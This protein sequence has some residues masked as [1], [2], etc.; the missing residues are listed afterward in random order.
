M[1]EPLFHVI[2]EGHPAAGFE[3][4]V[5]ATQL[6]QQL[7]LTAAQAGRLLGGSPVIAKRSVAHAVA[8]KYCAHLGALGLRVRIEPAAPPANHSTAPPSTPESD[9][10][11]QPQS[12]QPTHANWLELTDFFNGITTPLPQCRNARYVSRVLVAGALTAGIALVYGFLVLL[13]ALA[14]ILYTTSFYYLLTAPPLFFSIPVFV[15][16]WLL[17][18]ALN[19][20][21]WRP[22]L[23]LRSVSARYAML[24]AH[25]QP[26]LFHWLAQLCELVA[27]PMPREVA[28]GVQTGH[29]VRML[30]DRGAFRRADY[31]LIL[32]LP[33]LDAGSLRDNSALAAGLLTTQAEP[34]LLRCR[35]ML[36]VIHTRVA[37]C[38]ENRDW[39]S[40]WLAQRSNNNA[41]LQIP[42]LLHNRLLAAFAKRLAVV[43]QRLARCTVEE[44]DRLC[45][46]IAGSRQFAEMLAL[47][48]KLEQAARD[49]DALNRT[50]RSDGGLAVDLPALIHYYFVHFDPKAEQQLRKQWHDVTKR[51][52]PTSL[53]TAAE[54]VE[55]AHATHNDGIPNTEGSAAT[56]LGQADV[57]ARQ[58][59][60]AFYKQTGL[61]FEPHQLLSTETLTFAATED[62]LRRDQS[63]LYFNNW[64]KPFRFWLMADYALIRSMPV[65]D[66]T[67]Q[68]NVCVNEI[69]RL[70]PDRARLL[71]DYDRLQN[72]IQELLT[73]QLV[74]AQGRPFQFRY[75]TY[76]G[77]ALQPLIDDRQQQMAK[78]MEQLAVQETVMG[79]RISLGLRLCG[80]APRDAEQLHRALALT[81]GLD[82]RLYK[83]SLDV[84]KLEYLVQRHYLQREAHFSAPIKKLEEKIDDAC[85]LLRERLK[86]IPYPLD[87]RYATLESYASAQQ[88]G[89]PLE[90]DSKSA[91]LARAKSLLQIL[92]VF[93]EA[94]AGTAANFGSVAEEAYSIESI[95]LVAGS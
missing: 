35:H 38:L 15:L 64:F 19:V 49:A 30:E 87:A 42:L 86:E 77:V 76:D 6:Q 59:T 60:E 10:P 21:L 67:Q 8:K 94:L 54:R 68:L 57:L 75:L 13:G 43:Q 72:Q 11:A 83:L 14:L 95:R 84:C 31:Q 16:P 17:L 90:A 48:L 50:G 85:A 58:A 78:I 39:L 18:L 20:L 53:P 93:N 4:A 61:Q 45:A 88:A 33:L 9:P 81:S 36:E 32:S 3:S 89:S 23:P 37:A 71:N 56:L 1:T 2:A 79:G 22:L 29:G 28:V 24:H 63:A 27:V 12:I 41:A 65:A 70:T 91:T 26:Q 25:L 52:A 40:I 92:Y 69:R 82:S 7:K 74:L 34:K 66:A 47:Q 44:T 5:V 51:S 73:G 62:L 80:A 55:A 46:T